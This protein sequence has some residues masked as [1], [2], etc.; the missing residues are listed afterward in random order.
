M[1]RFMITRCTRTSHTLQGSSH[2]FHLSQGMHWK[3][4]PVIRTG[5]FSRPSQNHFVFHTCHSQVHVGGE[6]RRDKSTSTSFVHSV[7]STALRPFALLFTRE[8]RQERSWKVISVVSILFITGVASCRDRFAAENRVQT[9][10][11]LFL[12]KNTATNRLHR[13]SSLFHSRSLARNNV[14]IVFF[15]N[16]LR[17]ATHVCAIIPQTRSAL[18]LHFSFAAGDVG[19][20]RELSPI[21]RYTFALRANSPSNA[22][23]DVFCQH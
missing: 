1:T 19:R 12:L 17:T 11:F 5:F 3:D 10:V 15:S 8:L 9:D 14:V 6:P 21:R 4:S 23:F 22:A 13:I 18:D 2:L 16:Y 20:A 7:T